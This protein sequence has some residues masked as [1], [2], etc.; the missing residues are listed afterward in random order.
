[1]K[2]VPRRMALLLT[3]VIAGLATVG[4]ADRQTA[5]PS[6][7]QLLA[8]AGTYVAAY[9]KA[10]GAIVSEETYDQTGNARVATG[11]GRQRRV[12]TS[13]LLTFNTGGS[14]WMV[15]RDV[16]DVDGKPVAGERG[17]LATV[18]ADPS[19]EALADAMRR[20]AASA[21]YHIGLVARTITVPTAALTYLRRENQPHST[22]AFDGMKTIGK[23]SVALVTFA[24][25][26]EQPATD[27]ATTTKGRAWIEP[28]SGRI[29]RSEISQTSKNCTAKVEVE[30]AAEPGIDVWVPVRMFEQYDVVMP[31]GA[32]QGRGGQAV[33]AHVDGLATYRNFRQFALKAGLMI[34]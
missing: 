23:L 13:E 15:F 24:A 31:A 4:A 22:F 25:T 2:P 30:Y 19:R 20:T 29:V 17:R 1:M 28:E 5:N 26:D 7:A 12:T 32:V 27:D 6:L 11:P 3:V 9:E 18:A 14:G 8:A 21:R 16:L 10:F 33:S 34:R